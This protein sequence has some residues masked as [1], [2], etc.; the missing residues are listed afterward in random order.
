MVGEKEKSSKIKLPEYV[1]LS[2]EQI[3][4]KFV[5]R[6]PNFSGEESIYS[7]HGAPNVIDMDCGVHIRKKNFFDEVFWKNTVEICNPGRKRVEIVTSPIGGQ[8]ISPFPRYCSINHKEDQYEIPWLDINK[9]ISVR[10]NDRG[11]ITLSSN[12]IDTHCE[13][14]VYDSDSSTCPI[15]CARLDFVSEEKAKKIYAKQREHQR[16]M[17]NFLR[18]KGWIETR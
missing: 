15:A 3:T 8:I 2:V 11:H 17:Q 5:P 16:R 6:I 7:A 1:V 18:N 10:R 4:G 12:K 14:R 13:L 9:N